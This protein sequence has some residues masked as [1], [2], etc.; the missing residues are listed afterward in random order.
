MAQRSPAAASVEA[1]K[2]FQVALC[3]VIYDEAVPCVRRPE[4]LKV[5]DIRFLRLGEVGQ[6]GACCPGQK[7]AVVH[8]ERCQVLCLL[9][10]QKPFRA[11][12]VVKDC[13]SPA[14]QAHGANV[15][16][17]RYSAAVLYDELP[18]GIFE[19][20]LPD[21]CF[22]A[23]KPG[24]EPCG[25]VCPH[26]AASALVKDNGTKVVVVFGCQIDILGEGAGRDDAGYL[27]LENALGRLRVPDLLA[28]G[29]GIA[30]VNKLPGVAFH[31]MPGHAAHGDGGCGLLVAGGKRQLQ[32]PGADFG[33]VKKQFV[34][35][36]HAVEE[37]VV[38]VFF[39]DFQVLLKHGRDAVAF[40]QIFKICVR[41]CFC[42]GIG[43]GISAVIKG[44]SGHYSLCYV[45]GEQQGS[46]A[47]L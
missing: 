47:L 19:H 9:A 33:I 23:F 35:V 42:C 13:L 43:P 6:E 16:E 10:V 26:K 34:K 27:A 28:D 3:D 1:R 4:R 18:R 15:S 25:N 22:R 2:D 11:L 7:L 14:Y 20:P 37:Q 40:L 17:R 44:K 45:T 5:R 24:P 31:G 12:P 21:A 32:F 29:N 30:L 8:A 36:A 38:L 41:R 39:L 46:C